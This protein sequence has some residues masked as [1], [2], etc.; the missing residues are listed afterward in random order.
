MGEHRTGKNSLANGGLSGKNA[1]AENGPWERGGYETAKF[2]VLG[3][4]CASTSGRECL[5]P[6]EGSALMMP[7]LFDARRQP[8]EGTGDAVIPG[9]CAARPVS[10]CPALRGPGGARK[11]IFRYTA[12]DSEVNEK[13]DWS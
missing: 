13:E 8:C 9:V 11:G 4:T 2:L 5:L 7:F 10:D 1:V 6:L 3:S 12:V